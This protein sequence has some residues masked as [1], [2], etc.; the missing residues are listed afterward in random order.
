MNVI[1]H[2]FHSHIYENLLFFISSHPV[3]KG[4]WPQNYQMFASLPTLRPWRQWCSTKLW[5]LSKGRPLPRATGDTVVSLCGLLMKTEPCFSSSL[6][7]WGKDIQLNALPRESTTGADSEDRQNEQQYL[8]QDAS[9]ITCWW[10]CKCEACISVWSESVGHFHFLHH[11]S[12]SVY[13]AAISF[14]CTFS[15]STRRCTSV[16]MGRGQDV[17]VP[18]FALHPALMAA[19]PNAYREEAP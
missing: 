3:A 5:S 16:V 18:N 10:A 2:D 17:Q 7:C 6:Y 15:D 4:A 14:P 19:K 1:G 8:N 9:L 12:G 11:I 13:P